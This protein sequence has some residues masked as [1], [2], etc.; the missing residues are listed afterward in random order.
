MKRYREANKDRLREKRLHWEDANQVHRAEYDKAYR[1]ANRESRREYARQWALSNEGKVR[2]YRRH[3]NHTPAARAARARY[4]ANNPAKMAA[5]WAAREARKLQATP[6]W[7]DRGACD[8][9]Y[10]LARLATEL[11]GIKHSVDHIV[12]LRGKTV[13]GLHVQWNLRVVSQGEN[14]TK[15]NRYW[16]NMP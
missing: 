7:S 13:C 14:S 6:V 12:P 3:T 11:T 5:Q 8:A 4:A 9:L 16:P 1:E 2:G 15:G 10:D